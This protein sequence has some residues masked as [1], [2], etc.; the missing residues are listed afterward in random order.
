M[1][2][3]QLKLSSKLPASSILEVVIA[4]VI[5]VIVFGIA[6]MIY[7]NVLRF[8]LSGKKI[9]AEA[10]LQETLLAANQSKQYENRSF[11]VD[12]FSIQQEALPV[13]GSGR[14]MQF[15]LVALDINR[16]TVAKVQQLIIAH[17]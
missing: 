10:I 3:R 6:M 5:I 14:L 17:D 2:R 15:T 16:D 11:E 12:G 1:D 7:T 4:M 9:K 8:S 13:N